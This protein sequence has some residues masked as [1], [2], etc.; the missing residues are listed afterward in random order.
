M[1]ANKA[2]A[3]MNF[4]HFIQTYEAKYPQATACL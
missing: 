4:D 1:A 2:D 3:E